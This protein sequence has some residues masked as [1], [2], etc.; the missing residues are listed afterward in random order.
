MATMRAQRTS[1]DLGRKQ[2][3]ALILV[4]LIILLVIS[5]LGMSSVDSTGLEMQMATNNRD[6]QQT[7][8]AAEYT[9]AWVESVMKTNGYYSYTQVSNGSDGNSCGTICFNAACT[10]GYCFDGTVP[11][12]F[13]TCSFNVPGISPSTDA[14]IWAN[15]SGKH[16][17]LA[18]PNTTGITAKYII[19]FYCFTAKNATGIVAGNNNSVKQLFRIT[20]YVVGP[21]GSRVMLRS[22]V[23]GN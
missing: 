11:T 23:K 10:N 8:E 17:T 13:T 19:E 22:T 12:D 9:L 18:I 3:G 4:T 14:A 6:Q 7:F 15:G 20:A 2:G 21:G 16:Q 5:M 1:L